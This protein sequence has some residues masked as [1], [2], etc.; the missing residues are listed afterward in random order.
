MS[1]QHVDTLRGV[2]AHT[3][4]VIGQVRPDHLDLPT[5]CTEWNVRELL[6][7]TIGVVF[8]IAGS[9]TGEPAP[10]GDAPDFTT[11]DGAVVAFDQAS[12]R[13]LAAWSADGIFDGTVDFGAGD[14]PAEAGIGI[15]A[16]DTLT[17]SW[18][19]A[20]AIGHDRAMDPTIAEAV[21]AASKMIISDDIRAGRFGPAVTIDDA[22][23]AHDRLAAFLGRHPS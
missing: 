10:S 12:Q 1:N 13:S 6:N 5:P 8:G 2:Y 9:V 17:H 7:H 4:E 18:D 15:N 14:M 16:L 23:P 11:G 3:A 20:E 22:A 19:I 21:L